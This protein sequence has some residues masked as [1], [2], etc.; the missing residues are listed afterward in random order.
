MI[1]VA[2]NG[3]GV[4]GR[5][6]ADAVAK[7]PD[8]KL[9]GIGKTKPDYKARVAAGKGYKFFVPKKDHQ[10]IF[11]DAGIETSGT[12]DEMIEEADIIVDATPDNIGI[13]NK[14]L[15]QKIGKPALFQGGQ[16]HDIADLSF[17]A[18]CNYDQAQGKR[19]VRVVSCNTTGLC[20]VLSP[21]DKSFGVR[22]ARAV[23][24]RRAA[25]PDDTKSGPIDA[26]SLDPVTIP[27]HHGPDVMTVLPKIE[28][29]TMA[30]KI[31]TTHMHLHSLIV[32]LNESNLTQ[33][34]INETFVEAERV[35]LVSSADGVRSTAQV[36]DYAREL[37]RDRGDMYENIIWSDSVTVFDEEVYFFMGVHQESIVIPENID[38][39]RAIF[40]TSSKEESIS[41]TNTTLAIPH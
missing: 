39:I 32:S 38:A 13:L 26:I 31:P 27:S 9:V 25:D 8:M 37:G 10:G 41:L 16:K 7:Q 24:T 21:L 5:R 30:M 18:E 4:I 28:V 19:F 40:G 2:V 33:D 12:I 35:R 23:L 17:V 22:R 1:Q 14:G 36:M 15:Y 3:F 6:T 34:R 29:I 20:R 11:S